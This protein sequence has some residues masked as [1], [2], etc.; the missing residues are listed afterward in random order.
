MKKIIIPVI[1]LIIIFGCQS[2]KKTVESA[3]KK[4][5]QSTVWILKS[6]EKQTIDSNQLTKLSIVF[7]TNGRYSGNF[8]CN[9]FFGSYFA[10]K[11]KI[12][13][14]FAGATKKLCTDMDIEIIVSNIIKQNIS[15]Y[16]I[17]QDTLILLENKIEKLKFVA[18]NHFPD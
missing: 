4:S 12:T 16:K 10:K 7:D 8:G 15:K 9:K 3:S 1:L 6:I 11:Q 13:M 2:Q 18:A 17:Y 14:D 5:L